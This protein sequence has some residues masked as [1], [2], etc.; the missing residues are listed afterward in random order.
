LSQTTLADCAP[1]AYD[2]RDWNGKI[3]TVKT[4]PTD[5]SY[6]YIVTT[7]DAR[8]VRVSYDAEASF[9]LPRDH[10]VMDDECSERFDT[11][12]IAGWTNDYADAEQ[13]AEE[14]K[15]FVIDA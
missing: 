10:W 5:R 7:E 12:E 3:G 14:Y 2:G 13:A 6:F 8:V 4:L 15:R 9:W 1:D 11:D